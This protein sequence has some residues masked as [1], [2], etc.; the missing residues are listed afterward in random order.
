MSPKGK[1]K[2]P[3]VSTGTSEARKTASA[4]L[5]VLAGTLTPSGAASAIGISMPKYYLLEARALNAMV[6][7][8]EPRPKGRAMSPA[9]RM[10]ALQK[11]LE[12]LRRENA[13]QQTLLRAARRTIGLEPKDKPSKASDGKRHRTVKPSVRA[14]KV[15]AALRKPIEP[16]TA[17]VAPAGVIN[18]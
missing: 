17:E 11:E 13:R 18:P 6:E 15:I 14:L 16:A 2:G 3:N 7:S 5:E 8:C 12:N 9:S 1:S 4:I 10:D